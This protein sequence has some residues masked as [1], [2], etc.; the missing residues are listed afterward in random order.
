MS[1]KTPLSCW[2][3][4]IHPPPSCSAVFSCHGHITQRH[5]AQA[6][7]QQYSTAVNE[8]TANNDACWEVILYC[9]KTTN[10]L[11]QANRNKVDKDTVWWIL[12]CW[13]SV[14]SVL[15]SLK[16]KREKTFLLHLV[17]FKDWTESKWKSAP[18]NC[19]TPFLSI[20]CASNCLLKCDF[21]RFLDW[22]N[23]ISVAFKPWQSKHQ[24]RLFQK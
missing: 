15:V 6:C 17:R 20:Y 5:W 12:C 24:S 13:F 4:L 2:Y 23:S 19:K 16:R 8:N 7:R 3:T 21:S 1:V 9:G 11:L 10:L 22:P 14:M 18:R